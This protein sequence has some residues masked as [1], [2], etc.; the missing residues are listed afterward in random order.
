MQKNT[1][2]TIIIGGGFAGIGAAIQLKKAGIHN[3]LLLE[4]K[5]EIGGT[6]RD[7]TYP[8]CA[9]DIPSFLYS[10]SFELNPNWSESFSPHNEILNYL[11]HCVTEYGI[12][13]HIQY[14]T[15]V[16]E[17]IF[18]ATEGN[19][20]IHT[21]KKQ[22]FKSRTV[23]SC[24]GPLNEPIIPTFKNDTLFKGERFHS[25]HWNHNYDLKGKRVAVIGTGASAIQFIPKIA[26]MTKQLTV[27]QRTA[28]WIGKKD[29]QKFTEVSKKRFRKYPFYSRFWREVIYWV[30]EFRGLSQYKDNKIRAWRKK[31]AIAHLHNQIENNDLRRKLMPNYE[32]GCKRVLISDE[33]YPT[34]TQANVHLETSPISEFTEYGIR[35]QKGEEI[36]VDAII[37]G[38]GFKTTTF[39]HIYKIKGLDQENLFEKWNENGAEAFKGINVHGYP[40]LLFVV[41]P[42]TALGH[43]SIV[44]MM[45][46]Q[47]NYIIDYIKKIQRIP[48]S[49]YL[50]V[51]L[52]KQKKYNDKI[53]AELDKMIWS[54]GGCNSYYLRNGNG[55]N[56]S[57]WPGTT[58]KYRRLTKRIRLNDFNV[59]K[60]N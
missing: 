40:N 16:D 19:W 26:K 21:K 38:T 18:Q 3:F 1:Y 49:N 45:E 34:L 31:E 37:Y 24:S 11:K 54:T 39:S 22:L 13:T 41:G 56:T 47:F 20:E 5:N 36:E 2:E 42:N 15:E 48:S 30:L 33:Y 51:K 60:P 28:P 12:D 50:D 14:A 9:C 59:I 55:K 25:L 23:I 4:R 17:I 32:I 58:M 53:H 7:N 6:W 57:I 29:N 10:Y 35:N 27:F 46:S 43:N 44:H 8:G 52:E